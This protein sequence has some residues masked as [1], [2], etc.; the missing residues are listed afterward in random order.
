MNG[1]CNEFRQLVHA[2]VDGEVAGPRAMSLHLHAGACRACGL[3]LESA[4]EVSGALTRM[5]EQPAEPPAGLVQQ[6]MN[7]LPSRAGRRFPRA[8]WMAAAG[9]G[10]LAV[11]ALAGQALAALLGATP[12]PRLPGARIALETAGGWLQRFAALLEGLG[13][14]PNLLPVP[15]ALASGS[16]LLPGLALIATG[17]LGA[18]A[19]LTLSARLGLA[20]LR[21][22]SG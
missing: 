20:S 10:T 3:R 2:M 22:Q 12:S 4:R 14:V 7:R 15:P 8:G 13:E 17:L 21:R 18:A 6:I 1:V 11:L 5:S 19:A 16:S 9:A